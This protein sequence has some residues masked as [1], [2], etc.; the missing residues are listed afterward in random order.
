MIED[1]QEN[2]DGA[3]TLHVGSKAPVPGWRSRLVTS[4]RVAVGCN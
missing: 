3:Q 1:D 2:C 4:G